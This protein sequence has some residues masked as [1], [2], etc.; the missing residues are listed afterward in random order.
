MQPVVCG[1]D[2]TSSPLTYVAVIDDAPQ[3]HD[4]VSPD[5]PLAAPPANPRQ[6][7]AARAHADAARPRRFMGSQRAK[8]RFGYGAEPQ[9]R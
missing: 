7:A 4:P 9:K 2:C 6:H 1:W 8:R 3:V 5:A